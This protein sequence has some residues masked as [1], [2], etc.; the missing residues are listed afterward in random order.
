D[1][2]LHLRRL[3]EVAPG[4][5]GPAKAESGRLAQA[6]L[7]PRDRANLAGEPDLADDEHVRRHDAVHVARRCGHDDPEIGRGLG[8]AATAG[9]VH[10]DVL[11]AEPN[12]FFTARSTRYEWWRSPSK[13]STVSTRCSSTRG[14]ARA[15]SLVT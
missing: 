10:V 14:P 6:K 7:E 12:R 5:D 13:Y 11:A 1:V 8:D 4:H 9:D 3:E 2:E 15:P